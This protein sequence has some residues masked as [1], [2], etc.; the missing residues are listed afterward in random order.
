MENLSNNKPHS[1]FFIASLRGTKQSLAPLS[2]L[3]FGEMPQAEGLE[4]LGVRSYN[5]RNSQWLLLLLLSFFIFHFSFSQ[6]QP[7][8]NRLYTNN[9]FGSIYVAA[10]PQGNK[11]G[12]MT[13]AMAT[14]SA[15]NGQGMRISRFNSEGIF[16]RCWCLEIVFHNFHQQL[17]VKK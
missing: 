4:G 15:T 1:S 8:F 11:G 12:F 13:V 3:P 7:Y 6:A 2:I 17:K 10:S 14:D 5:S 16:R 9:A